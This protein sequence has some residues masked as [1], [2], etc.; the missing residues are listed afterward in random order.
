MSY[1]VPKCMFSLCDLT[2]F[3]V[4]VTNAC[5]CRSGGDGDEGL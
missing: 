4:L 5:S 2:G 3:R 1:V